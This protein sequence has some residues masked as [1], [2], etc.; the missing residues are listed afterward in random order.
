MCDDKIGCQAPSCLID[1]SATQ[2]TWLWELH[3]MQC[4]GICF[5]CKLL[6]F[7]ILTQKHSFIL[8]TSTDN[9]CHNMWHQ[10][11]T[12]T[13]NLS[14]RMTN[15]L[16]SKNDPPIIFVRE[17]GHFYVTLHTYPLHHL[18]SDSKSPGLLFRQTDRRHAQSL[19]LEI[20]QMGCPAE[21]ILWICFSEKNTRLLTKTTQE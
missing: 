2:P 20:G 3:C 9:P 8:W 12:F 4:V 17:D 14:S 10:S 15:I 1:S 6:N 21:H 19:S 11:I 16:R 7:Y 13:G 5:N 18:H